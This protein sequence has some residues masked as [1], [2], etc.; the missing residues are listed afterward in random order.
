MQELTL[1]CVH[2]TAASLSLAAIWYTFSKIVVCMR[3]RSEF[4]IKQE[5]ILTQT[6]F[7]YMKFIKEFISNRRATLKTARGQ[8]TGSGKRKKF[9]LPHSVPQPISPVTRFKP[10][11]IPLHYA[12]YFP[13]RIITSPTFA[14]FQILGAFAKLR[15]VTISFVTSVCLSVFPS[16]LPTAWNKSAPTGRIVWNSILE[17]FSKIC[18]ENSSFVKI[19]KER[20]LYMKTQ[21]CLW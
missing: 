3:G 16:V 13:C 6:L 18:S 11:F 5:T 20:V 12:T 9:P 7:S 2:K 21:V 10:R 4:T 14:T 17:Y 15:N 8:A 1:L 19:W